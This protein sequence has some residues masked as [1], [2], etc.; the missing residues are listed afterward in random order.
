MSLYR[1]VSHLF[2]SKFHQT[3]EST[4]SRHIL[5]VEFSECPS[6]CFESFQI[7]RMNYTNILAVPKFSILLLYIRIFPGTRFVLITKAAIGWM[8]CHT[9]VF[10]FLV[11]FQ[12]TPVAHF[13]D[14]TIPGHCLNTPVLVYTGGAFSIIEDIVIMFLPVSELKNLN[15]SRR[16]RVGLIL[17]FVLGSL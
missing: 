13:W 14:A 6:Q 9:L 16:K 12:C 15:M 2:P 8:I 5:A 7:W 17:M 10:L 4:L 1:I 3:R 11:A